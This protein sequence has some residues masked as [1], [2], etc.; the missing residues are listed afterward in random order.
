MPIAV[1][2]ARA[3]ASKDSDWELQYALY[4]AL[5]NAVK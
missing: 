1:H 3:D 2:S 5:K 4:E